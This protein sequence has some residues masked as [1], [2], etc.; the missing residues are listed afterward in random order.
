M[1]CCLPQHSGLFRASTRHSLVAPAVNPVQKSSRRVA[2]IRATA[3]DSNS[4]KALPF[5]DFRNGVARE[6]LRRG[7]GTGKALGLEPWTYGLKVP[8]EAC[9]WLRWGFQLAV[10]LLL[11]QTLWMLQRSFKNGSKWP[12]EVLY[13]YRSATTFFSLLSRS[14][15]LI[16][17]ANS[18]R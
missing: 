15:S 10:F 8:A 1:P 16:I 4:C 2:Y 9:C 3:Q 6:S 13:H 7:F 11:K 14:N 12:P 5:H 18:S 17:L